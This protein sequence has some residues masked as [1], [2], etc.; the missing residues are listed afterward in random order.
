MATVNEIS[1]AIVKSIYRHINCLNDENRNM[2]KIALENIRND[3]IYHKPP[4][5]M[6]ELEYIFSEIMKPLLKSFSD[7]VEKCREISIVIVQSFF[8]V[9]SELSERL[10]YV[11][12][13]IVQRLGQQDIIEPSEEIRLQLMRLLSL[14]IDK[15]G[16]NISVYMDDITKVLVRTLIDAFPDIRKESCLCCSQIAK[17]IPDTFHMV[18]ESYINPLLLSITH[19][20]SKNRRLVVTTIGMY[21][22]ILETLFC[23]A[24][25]FI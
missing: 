7:P 9:I 20:H 10:S 13:V 19:Q 25:N 2:R 3:T 12:P 15:S 17:S 23:V 5:N 22:H 4:L 16:C 24:Y 8:A 11:I 18:S 1:N 21:R 14:I 6:D